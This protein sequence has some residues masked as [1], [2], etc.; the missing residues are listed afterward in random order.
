MQEE[1]VAVV[2]QGTKEGRAAGTFQFVF[3]ARDAKALGS[4][5]TVGRGT[6]VR[7]RERVQRCWNCNLCMSLS[8][9]S[10]IFCCEGTAARVSSSQQQAAY[11]R[12]AKTT[13]G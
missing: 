11:T 10:I 9:A 6:R 12:V 5:F 2:L 1:W 13:N 3:V 4:G 7:S 8:F